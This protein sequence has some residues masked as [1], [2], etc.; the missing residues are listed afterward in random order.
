[1][2]DHPHPKRDLKKVAR[3][4]SNTSQNRNKIDNSKVLTWSRLLNVRF[5]DIEQISWSFTFRCLR[6]KSSNV[7]LI[8]K[9]YSLKTKEFSFSVGLSRGP[10]FHLLSLALI[11]SYRSS[12]DNNKRGILMDQIQRTLAHSV[13]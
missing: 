11:Q 10:I 7:S 6:Q 3:S 1:M 13:F 8:K 2:E 9:M 4:F 5:N 12:P